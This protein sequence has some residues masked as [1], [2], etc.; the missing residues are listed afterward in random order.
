MI[1]GEQQFVRKG[2][3]GEWKN[4][5]GEETNIKADKWI[6]ENLKGTDLRFPD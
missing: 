4:E 2:K 3:N 6:E 1:Q 5:F